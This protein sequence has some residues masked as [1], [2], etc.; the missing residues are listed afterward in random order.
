MKILPVES[1]SSINTLSLKFIPAILEQWT[2]VRWYHLL[3][4]SISTSIFCA[5]CAWFVPKKVTTK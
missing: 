3:A 1:T 5:L 4:V 2:E